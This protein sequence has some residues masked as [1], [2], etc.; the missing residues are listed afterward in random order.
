[1]RSRRGNVAVPR[2]PDG[3]WVALAQDAGAYDGVVLPP[4]GVEIRETAQWRR[5][6]V[7][8]LGSPRTN[9]FRFFRF[10]PDSRFLAAS[11]S[12]DVVRV[13]EVQSL[14]PAPHPLRAGLRAKRIVWVPRTH[15]L[16]VGCLD[17]SAHFWNVDTDD[18]KVLRPE[19]GNV[20]ALDISPD[21]RTFAIGTQDGLLK[22]INLPT[23]REI[24]T[25]KGHLTTFADVAFSPDGRLLISSSETTRIRRAFVPDEEQA[26]PTA[27]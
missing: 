2:S 20:S 25:L 23:R 15:T 3:R 22:L 13:L 9:S 12:D 21:G 8:Q 26:G 6:G 16:C 24:A 17:A 5:H 1:M 11:C 7:W 18:A 4:R 27:P 14:R 10:S 19:A